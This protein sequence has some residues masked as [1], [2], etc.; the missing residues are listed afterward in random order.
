MRAIAEE[1][2]LLVEGHFG[3][4]EGENAGYAYQH[5]VDLQ[6]GPVVRPLFDVQRDRVVLGHIQ[7]ADAANGPLPGNGGRSGV[8]EG[9]AG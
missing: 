5:D 7:L 1:L 2:A 9:H 6:A 8:R 4:I 3:L